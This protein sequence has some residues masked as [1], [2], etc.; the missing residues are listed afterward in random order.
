MKDIP[1]TK[2]TCA[3]I[4]T[5]ANHY[6]PKYFKDPSV[7]RPERWE[8][9]C[10]KL[11]PYVFLG[12]SAGPKVCPGKQMA[13]LETKITLVKLALKYSKFSL[14]KEDLK[15]HFELIYGPEPF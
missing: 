13:L 5:L 6:N 10:D 8:S 9:E 3:N 7:F 14:E 4:D 15:L 2:G 11:P 1:I 12:F